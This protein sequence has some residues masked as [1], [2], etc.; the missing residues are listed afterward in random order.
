M[1]IVRYADDF[2]V[3]CRYR[4]DAEKV[5]IAIKQWLHERLKLEVS[6]EKS[7][8]CNLKKQYSEFLGFKFKV[9][10]K[11]THYTTRTHMSDKAV[12]RETKN[13]IE[14]V[15]RISR[16]K[17]DKDEALMVCKY[18]AMVIGMQNYYCVASCVSQDCAKIAYQVN[19]VLKT[20]L[21]GRL[22]KQGSYELHN[23]IGQRYGNSKQMRYVHGQPVVPVGYVQYRIPHWKKKKVCKYTASG[24]AE[25]HKNL[26]LDMDILLKLMRNP[27]I[28][29]SIE[30]RV[31][32]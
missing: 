29:R 20:R 11:G 14:Q 1:Y 7:K 16:P 12:Q 6:E 27:S 24:R 4:A 10:R 17:D 26:G 9:I 13:L 25:I 5:F 21:K 3:F 8:I 18:N 15:K 2:K 32:G 19:R 30:Y 28:G 31:Y 22:K 23:Y